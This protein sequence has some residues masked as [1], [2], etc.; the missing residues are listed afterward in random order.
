MHQIWTQI[1]IQQNDAKLML[2]HGP[3]VD[4]IEDSGLYYLKIIFQGSSACHSTAHNTSKAAI[5]GGIDLWHQRLG[6]LNKD[7]AHH[8]L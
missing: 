6:H 4:L 2:S 5:K 7:D 8:W 1:Y 3:Q